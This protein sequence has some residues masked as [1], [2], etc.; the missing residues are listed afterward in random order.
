MRCKSYM[1]SYNL[2]LELKEKRIIFAPFFRAISS[3]GLE[4]L[5]YKQGV[6]GSNPTSPTGCLKGFGS[7]PEPFFVCAELD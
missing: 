2:G 6:V 3:V 5:P 1:S 4:H 7:F